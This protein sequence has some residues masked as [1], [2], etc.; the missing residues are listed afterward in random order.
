MRYIFAPFRFI[1]KV[2]FALIFGISLILFAQAFLI[3]VQFKNG[4]KYGFTWR[5]VWSKFLEIFCLVPVVIQGKEN[6]PDSGPYIVVANH[7]SYLDIIL[8]Y[9]IVPHQF[10]FLGKA[11][12]LGW[13][14][15]RSVFS[16][17]DIAVERGTRFQA[18][19]S[20]EKCGEALKAGDCIV[21]FPEGGWDPKNKGLQR[22]KNG[23]F[24]LALA[25]Q[26]PIMPLTFQNNK[27][28]FCD[29][30]DLFFNGRPG[31]SRTVAHPMVETKGMTAEDLVHLRE[32]IFETINSA[33]PDEY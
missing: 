6:F 27:M 21:I 4:F 28:L 18:F 20:L 32:E 3:A 12:I 5:R 11:E 24:K 8:L 1:Y 26:V 25:N 19:R 31:I 14:I 7:A 23:A 16:K 22:F 13:P 29:H 10:R 33:L 2:Y 9:G 17:M 15:L 30:T